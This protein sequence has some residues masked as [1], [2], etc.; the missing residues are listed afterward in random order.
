MA[1]KK[2]N[3]TPQF[4]IE[5]K[6]NRTFSEE[7]RRNKIKDLVEK[8]VSIKQ[9]CDLYQITRTTVYNWLYLY[10][11]H[12]SSGVKTVVQMESEAHRTQQFLQ[13]IAELERIVGQKQLELDY[14]NKLIEVASVELDYDIKKNIAQKQ[15][16][17]LEVTPPSIVTK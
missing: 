6:Y 13:R 8:R 3:K 16:S 12:H 14:A 17:G 7:F 5:S 2:L 1:S 9:L 10:S 11:P 4:K 15:S